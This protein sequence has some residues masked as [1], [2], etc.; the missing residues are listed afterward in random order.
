MISHHLNPAATVDAIVSSEPTETSTIDARGILTQI[1]MQYILFRATNCA[2]IMSTVQGGYAHRGKF[3][4]A[5][6]EQLRLSNGDTNILEM[7]SAASNA[8]EKDA[9]VKYQVPE[10]RTTLRK[11]LRL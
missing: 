5:F 8:V 1:E 9:E 7:F 3:V 2:L 4:T 6:S 10:C 11:T